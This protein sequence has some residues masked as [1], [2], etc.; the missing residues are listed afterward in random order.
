MALH[1]RVSS[2]VRVRCHASLREHGL[3]HLKMSLLVSRMLQKILTA[4]RLSLVSPPHVSGRCHRL[5]RLC[6]PGWG[7]KRFTVVR[8]QTY[9]ASTR[10]SSVSRAHDWSPAFAPPH[11]WRVSFP[12]GVERALPVPGSG[13]QRPPGSRP[14]PRHWGVS[15]SPLGS[16]LS[17]SGLLQAIVTFIPTS[18]VFL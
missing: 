14:W 3:G 4:M 18:C 9:S 10:V 5:D 1:R 12:W 16:D 2:R 11:T 6:S 17:W 8:V 7:E 15:R 13:Q